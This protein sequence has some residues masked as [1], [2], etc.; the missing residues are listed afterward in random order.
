MA[1]FSF[2]ITPNTIP[3]DLA[4]VYI[5]Q[6]VNQYLEEQIDIAIPIRAD[7]SNE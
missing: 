4:R 2:L 7:H 3:S 6:S 1:N 5:V